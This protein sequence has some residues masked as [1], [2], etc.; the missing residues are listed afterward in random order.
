MGGLGFQDLE[1]LNKAILAKQGWR[2]MNNSNLLISKVLSASYY[3]DSDFIRAR[4]GSKT[5]NNILHNKGKR[6][7]HDLAEWVDDFLT[8]YKGANANNSK[9][10][11]NEMVKWMPPPSGE[12]KINTDAAVNM[13][14]GEVGIGAVCRDAEGC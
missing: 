4:T 1:I 9:I 6:K 5:L 2:I 12:Y 14:A 13:E 8:E 10:V 7:G 11:V 3:P